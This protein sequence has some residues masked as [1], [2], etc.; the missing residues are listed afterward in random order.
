MIDT[1]NMVIYHRILAK[2]NCETP[3]YFDYVILI[4]SYDFNNLLKF[5]ISKT[6]LFLLV[7]YLK[8]GT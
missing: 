6:L 1:I 3:A 4:K 5:L 2:L 7:V 8:E